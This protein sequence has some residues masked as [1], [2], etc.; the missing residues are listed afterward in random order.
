MGTLC[1]AAWDN[2]FEAFGKQDLDKIMLLCCRGDCR[3][4][5]MF[6]HKLSRSERKS[7]QTDG[8]QPNDPH[9]HRT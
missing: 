2:H 6:E 8:W 7:N 1:E 4:P 5:C 3:Q 9:I